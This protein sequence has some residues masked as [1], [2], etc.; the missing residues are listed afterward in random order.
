MKMEISITLLLVFLFAIFS[1]AQ[2]IKIEHQR[3][4]LRAEFVYSFANRP[5]PECHASTVVETDRGILVAWFGGTEEGTQDVDIWT[6]LHNGTNWSVPVQVADGN[7]EDGSSLPCW[8]PVLFQPKKGA[9]MLFYKVGKNPRDWWGELK[10]STDA[11]L[12]WSKAERLPQGILGPIKNKPVQLPDGNILCGSSKENNGWQVYFEITRDLGKT[13]KSIGPVN[14]ANEF[15]AIQPALFMHVEKRDTTL[16]ALCRTRQGCIAEVSSTD[17]GKKWSSMRCTK[18]CNPNSGIDGVTLRDGRHLLVYNNTHQGRTPLNA[19]ISKN[20]KKWKDVLR[21]EEQPGEYS[22][23]AI[24]QS[25]DGLVH[26]TYTWQRQ[27]IKHVVLNPND[28]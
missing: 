19:A 5:T 12:T 2:N 24:I 10:S 16:L 4:Y 7:Q 6:S 11:G 13:W 18:L 14:N 28:L 3:G 25:S 23:P 22:Y 27:T 8:N 21:L 26:I 9:L 20:S 17:M 1:R 15:S